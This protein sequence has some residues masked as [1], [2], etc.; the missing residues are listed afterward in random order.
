MIFQSK[1]RSVPRIH[2]NMYP[3]AACADSA[4]CSTGV[5]SY[6][7]LGGGGAF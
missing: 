3:T 2:S 4:T 7:S 6:I 5:D 1:K